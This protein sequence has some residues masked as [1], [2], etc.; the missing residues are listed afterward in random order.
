MDIKGI[1]ALDD[2]EAIMAGP[3]LPVSRS[4]PAKDQWDDRVLARLRQAMADRDLDALLVVRAE[5]VCWLTHWWD[6]GQM[7][8]M[9]SEENAW[10]VVPREGEPFGLG[11]G[12]VSWGMEMPTRPNWLKQMYAFDM[13]SFDGEAQPT[14]RLLKHQG[15]GKGRI[16][17]E[18]EW[19]PYQYVRLL[20]EQ[21]PEVEF[22]GSDAI[23]YQLRSE[24]SAFEI[25]II[26]KAV[27]VFNE[28]LEV[29]VEHLSRNRDIERA[30]RVLSTEMAARNGRAA[31]VPTCQQYG[32]GWLGEDS[33][34][35]RIARDWFNAKTYDP[36]TEL[37][38]GDFCMTYE[39]YWVDLSLYEWINP[40]KARSQRAQIHEQQQRLD[41]M[42]LL[43]NRAIRPGMTGVE[44]ERA[45]EQAQADTGMDFHYWFHSIGLN[46]HEQPIVGRGETARSDVRYEVG[47]V[48]CTEVFAEGILYEDMVHLTEN[49]WTY[50]TTRRPFIRG[51]AAP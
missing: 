17:I 7:T 45:I 37:F 4:D 13:A 27:G 29:A 15:L 31:I 50:L 6:H 51:D 24:K 43:M 19:M 10:V 32:F 22:D 18:V 35:G 41:E 25:E 39:G 49:G 34:D 1:V 38:R 2:R 26:R 46:I 44:A 20:Q 21:L 14:C 30:M 33:Q 47:V 23:F 12:A 11:T 5:N 48:A 36:E 42:Q 16:G 28:S 9:P 40:D 3:G 8:L